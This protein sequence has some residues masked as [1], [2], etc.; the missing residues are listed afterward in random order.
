[1]ENAAAHAFARQWIAAW[2]HRDLDALLKHYSDD[3]EFRSPL[4]ARLFGADSGTIRGKET[5]RSYFTKALVAFPGELDI[6]LL[7]VYQ[8]IDSIVV[9][10]QA[11][12]RQGA[13][14]MEFNGDNVVHRALAHAQ[15][16]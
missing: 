9:L 7:G 12:G 15:A 16:V 2:K 6:E 1:M 8:G 5:L 4:A 11:R 14:F 3:V 13:E 10:F